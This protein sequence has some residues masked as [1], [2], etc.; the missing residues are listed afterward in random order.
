MTRTTSGGPSPRE[1]A[2]YR[3][4]LVRARNDSEAPVYDFQVRVRLN[5]AENASSHGSPNDPPMIL[6]PGEHAIWVDLVDFSV[7][8]LAGMPYVDFTFK[9]DRNR[10]WQRLHDGS[11]GRDRLSQAGWSKSVRG[12]WWALVRSKRRVMLRLKGPGA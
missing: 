11:L 10:R 8:E 2:Q 6:P 5:Y 7:G 1:D 9:D 3:S 12:R 4:V